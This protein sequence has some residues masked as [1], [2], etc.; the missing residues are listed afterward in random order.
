M[1]LQVLIVFITP[2]VFVL[3]TVT[4]LLINGIVYASKRAVRKYHVKDLQNGSKGGARGHSSHNEWVKK[5]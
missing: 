4:T 3:Q 5:M 1:I 2:K